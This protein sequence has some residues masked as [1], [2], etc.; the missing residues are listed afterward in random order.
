MK[1]ETCWLIKTTITSALSN[2]LQ[3]GILFSSITHRI[4]FSTTQITQATG[5]TFVCMEITIVVD[6]VPRLGFS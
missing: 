1:G 6:L 5:D 2:Y 3:N 4:L